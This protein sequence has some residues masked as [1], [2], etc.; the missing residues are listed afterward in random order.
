[1]SLFKRHRFPVEIAVLCVRWYSK[2]GISYRDLA[3]MTSERG[4]EVDPSALFRWVQ[5]FA[6]EIQKRV[7]PYQKP[8]SVSWRVDETYVQLDGK[9]KYLFRAVG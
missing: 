3:K 9:W 1:M 7:R 8:R 2:Y 5:R 4:V 6:P